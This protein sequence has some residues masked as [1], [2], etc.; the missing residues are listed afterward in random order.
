MGSNQALLK[1]TSLPHY[2]VYALFSSNRDLPLT[3][4]VKYALLRLLDLSLNSE[5]AILNL[6]LSVGVMVNNSIVNTMEYVFNLVD[7]K[8]TVEFGAALITV[9]LL[10]ATSDASINTPAFGQI[11]NIFVKCVRWVAVTRSMGTSLSRIHA[12]SFNEENCATMHRL[13]SIV[14]YLLLEKHRDEAVLRARPDVLHK[15]NISLLWHEGRLTPLPDPLH[16][17]HHLRG[18]EVGL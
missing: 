6:I 14:D 10:Q 1:A 17:H 3:W 4:C 18:P 15:T 11:I 16:L 8:S 9:M 13:F 12:Q 5:E 2:L 7:S